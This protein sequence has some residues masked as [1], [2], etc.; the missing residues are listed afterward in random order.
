MVLIEI[1]R[2]FVPERAVAHC[3]TC[4]LVVTIPILNKGPVSVGQ[5]VFIELVELAQ[6]SLIHVLI[7]GD[8]RLRAV[9]AIHQTKVITPRNDSVP[10]LASLFKVANVLI[11]DAE[12]IAQPC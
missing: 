10:C 7:G 2:R 8:T 11:T 6:T 5:Q 1:I 9:G 3:V 12:V 4:R